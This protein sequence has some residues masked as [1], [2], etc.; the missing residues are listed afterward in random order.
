MKR[1][2][3]FIMIAMLLMSIVGCGSKEEK[4]SINVFKLG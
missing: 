3:S 1:V 4:V 2:V